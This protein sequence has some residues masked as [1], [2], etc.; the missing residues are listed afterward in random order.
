MEE[1]QDETRGVIGDAGGIEGGAIRHEPLAQGLHRPLVQHRQD[2]I[3]ANITR[4]DECPRHVL[5]HS[6]VTGEVGQCML[7]CC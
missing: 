7:G 3:V 6:H 4:T 1:G 5:D 2:T